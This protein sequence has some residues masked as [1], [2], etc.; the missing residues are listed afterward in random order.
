MLTPEIVLGPELQHLMVHGLQLGLRIYV[1]HAMPLSCPQQLVFV[2]AQWSSGHGL[3][4]GHSGDEE[5]GVH[6][7]DPPELISWNFWRI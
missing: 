2:P 4:Q 3:E 6:Q 7:E 5:K 1:N